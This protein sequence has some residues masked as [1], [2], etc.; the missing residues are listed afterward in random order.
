MNQPADRTILTILRQQKLAPVMV[1]AVA[2][3]AATNWILSPEEASRWLRNML[4]LPLLWLGLTL[5]HYRT[6]R[7]VRERKVDDESAVTRYFSSTLS[8]VIVA[9]GI[10]QIVTLSLTIWVRLGDHGA[11]IE[12]GRRI[13]GIATGL[14]WIIF[15]NTIPK[16]LTPFAML[17]PDLAARV[18][19]ARRFVGTAAVLLGLATIIAFLLAPLEIAQALFDWALVAGGLALVGAIV[20]MNLAPQRRN[21]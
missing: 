10:L 13:L 7:S 15:G 11:D 3:L 1:L 8:L 17:P 9:L 21:R 5:W 14:V 6:L 18:T 4:I 12:M 19:T 16:I 20:W 2:L